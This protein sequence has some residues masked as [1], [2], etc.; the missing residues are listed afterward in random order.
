MIGGA[1]AD[2]RL[3]YG[4]NAGV[5]QRRNGF[6][7]GLEAA[8]HLGIRRDVLR[9]DLDGHLAIESQIPGSVHLA[10]ASGAKGRHDFI[11]SKTLTRREWHVRG[12]EIIVTRGGTR[13]L[14]TDP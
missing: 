5:R 2:A 4:E 6:G 1:L 12:V 7:F 3:V 8:P 14:I 10:H 11:L 13:S 9:H